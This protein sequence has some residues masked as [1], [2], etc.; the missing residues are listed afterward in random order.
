MYIFK[1]SFCKHNYEF[2]SSIHG[3]WIT[4]TGGNRS[5]WKCTKCG[6]YTYSTDYVDENKRQ[7]LLRLKKLKK[8][9]NEYN[10]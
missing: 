2:S 6:K 10:L 7:Q 3:D 8:L 9:K 5:I 1:K 4:R